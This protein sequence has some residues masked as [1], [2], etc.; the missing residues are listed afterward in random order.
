MKIKAWLI[1]AGISALAFFRGAIVASIVPPFQAPDEP[2]HF[3][4]VQRIAE[5]GHLPELRPSPLYSKEN[6]ALADAMVDPIAFQPDRPLPPLSA[7]IPPDPANAT[8]RA[9]TGWSPAAAYPPLYY[10]TGAAAYALSSPQAPLLHR[11]FAARFASIFWGTLATSF[12][13]LLGLGWFRSERDALLLALLL[14][15]QPMNS[16]LFGVVNPDSALIACT[17]GCFAAIAWCRFSESRGRALWLLCACALAGA[18][19]KPTFSLML[20]IICTCCLMALGPRRRGAWLLTASAIVPAAIA[21]IAWSWHTRLA[22]K[23]M[24]DTV[25]PIPLGKYLATWVFDGPRLYDLW[26]RDYWMAWGWLDTRLASGYYRVLAAFLALAAAG[27]VFGWRRL[28]R[29]E[30]WAM[31]LIVGSTL[32]A[33]VALYSLEYHVITPRMQLLQGRY[34]LPLFPLHAL[35]LVTGLR[36]LSRRLGAAVDAPWVFAAT[37]AVINVATIARLMTRY[38]S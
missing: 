14:V 32:Y 7:F 18:L 13:F 38:Y 6:R 4:Y 25:L 16:L 9:T 23:T 22:V 29:E 3:D 10:A 27:M 33:L 28:L 17:T 8:S 21:A 19:V 26:M 37:L 31:V 2:A 20:P 34:L 1:L 11:L 15:L 12:A 35:L 36:A 30:R 5:H 24:Y